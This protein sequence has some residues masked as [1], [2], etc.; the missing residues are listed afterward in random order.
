MKIV[1][2]RNLVIG[3]GR[4][5]ICVPLMGDKDSVFRTA[6]AI[7]KTHADMVEWRADTD[8][9]PKD[10]ESVLKTAEML[11]KIL[12]NVPLLFTFRTKEEG[13]CAD[14]SENDYKELNLK[15]I[16]SGLID[17]IDIEFF[18]DEKNLKELIKCAR[19][20]S[21]ATV[22]SSHDFKKTPSVVE[23][24]KRLT[25]MQKAGGDLVK[26]AVM[27][28]SDSDVIQLLLATWEMKKSYSDTPVITMSMGGRGAL[29]RISGELFGSAVT[30]AAYEK[31]SAPGQLQVEEV[32]EIMEKLHL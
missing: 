27:P 13:G 23:I 20:H 26:M 1:K 3:E 17:L 21:I 30:F 4:P 5:K 32:Y 7:R 2:I 9:N 10:Q 6:E 8:P 11:R 14:I 19:E 22:L 25:D 28:Q 18:R 16:R 12:G 15:M 24:V 31:V 29:S